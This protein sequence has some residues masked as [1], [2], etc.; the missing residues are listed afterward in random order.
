MLSVVLL[1]NA[2][3][4]SQH[5]SSLRVIEKADDSIESIRAISTIKSMDNSAFDAGTFTDQNG[6]SIQYRLFSPDTAYANKKRYPLIIIFHGSGQTGTDNMI[7]LSLLPK[8]FAGKEN[9]Q[10]HPSYVLAP[11]FATRSSD[12]GMDSTRKV[13][14][15]APRPCLQS[16]LALVDS[17]KNNLNID[18]QRIYIAGYS[19]GGSTVI[20]A[21]SARPDLFAAGIS[22]AGI[23]AFEHAHKFSQIPLWLI[24]GM[25]DPENHISSDEAFYAAYSQ[26]NRI[27]FWKLKKRGHHNLF[28]MK[29]LGTTLPD[30]LYRQHKNDRNSL[31]LN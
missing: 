14:S 30:W 10:K 25:N 1:L 22:L 4:S 26:T 24:H 29:L 7:Q 31:H 9:Q 27:R 23:P 28:C 11:Q 16:L 17:L 8:L 5:H 21:L 3:R 6:V 13:L 19:M 20:N 12:Y 2:C 15:S 18:H